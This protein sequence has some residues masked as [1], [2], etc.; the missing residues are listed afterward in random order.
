MNKSDFELSNLL[1]DD[2]VAD[3]R[4][5]PRILELESNLNESDEEKHGNICNEKTILDY[6]LP[7]KS[8]ELIHLIVLATANS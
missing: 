1:D 2:Y 3:K 8:F 5:E 4:Y 6:P 7:L